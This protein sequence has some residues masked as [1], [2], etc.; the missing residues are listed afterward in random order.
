MK[1]TKIFALFL[2]IIMALSLLSGCG[3]AKTSNQNKSGDTNGKK[4]NITIVLVK[5]DKTT[6]EFKLTTKEGNSLRQALY[7][8]KLITDTE[9]YDQFVQVIDGEKA[10]MEDGNLWLPC[11][12]NGNKLSTSMDTTKVSDGTTYKLVYTTAPNVDD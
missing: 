11:D 1:K 3:S 4:V 7:E 5:K 6:K 8:N 9:N 2:T 10:S 12:A